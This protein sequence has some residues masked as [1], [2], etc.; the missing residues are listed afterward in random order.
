MEYARD[1]G[2]GGAGVFVVWDQGFDLHE[3]TV[4]L[5]H[6]NQRRHD[7]PAVGVEPEV[8][9][10]LGVGDQMLHPE[11]GQDRVHGV[12]RLD[13]GFQ[14]G[15][16]GSVAAFERKDGRNENECRYR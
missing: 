5:G 15:G 11:R 8:L 6:P 9:A 2:V 3:R 7:L 16:A 13:A 10:F 14:L 1:R 4:D 12:C